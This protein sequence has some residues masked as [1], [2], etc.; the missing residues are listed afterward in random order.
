MAAE[1]IIGRT[2]EQK[3]LQEILNSKEAEF[4]A[5]YGRRRV[6]KT[7]L[8]REFFAA[9][10]LF[11]V[12]GEHGRAARLQLDRFCH[13]VTH[14]FFDGRPL[15]PCASWS[16]A[17][18]LLSGAI[19]NFAERHPGK[20]IVVFLDE[21]PWLAT[22]RSGLVAAL[23]HAWNARLSKVKTL[24][25]IVC[26]SAASWMLD[27]FIHAKGGLYNRITQRIHLRPFTL[28]ETDA[29]LRARGVKLNN[30]QVALL[31]MTVG[32][33]P[34]YLKQVRRGRSVTQVVG[35]LC[36]GRDGIL[37]DEFDNLFRSL[38]N[39]SEVHA[40]IVRAL[41]ARTRGMSQSEL[42]EQTGLS[43]GGRFRKYLDELES[44][45]FIASFNPFGKKKKNTQYRLIDEYSYFYLR[46]IDGAPSAALQGDGARYWQRKA[47][48]QA[49]AA[50]SGYA[51][52]NLCFKH[53][54]QLLEA[55][56]L[57]AIGV[58]SSTWRHL[59]GPGRPEAGRGA[60]IDLLLDR[61]DDTITLCEMKFTESAFTIDRKHARELMEKIGV[62][63]AVTKTRK[64]IQLVMVSAA[65]LKANSFSED[66]VADCVSLEAFFT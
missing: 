65:G 54:D 35:E 39:R 21:L 57:S 36:F 53:V 2:G 34:H 64:S 10:T 11:E 40:S 3:R 42:V 45:G 18:E 58:D 26:G 56:G 24:R 4:I 37:R 61:E 19:E 6:G 63:E 28:S 46:W 55:L 17:L 23:D 9:H 47:R 50:W 8:I 48:S 59:P 43:G 29:F 31:Y 44:S 41:A 62:F 14:V 66:L 22:H 51:F 25:L 5:L 1:S 33:V 20:P 52:E 12:T 32:G 16:A 27:K 13:E 49:F 15:P 30:R 60:Q 38:F 7:F